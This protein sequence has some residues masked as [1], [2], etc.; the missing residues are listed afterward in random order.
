MVGEI[1]DKE[2]AEIAIHA[3]LTGHLVLST[4]HTNDAAGAVTRLVEMGVEP[5][6]VALDVIGV[7]AQRLVRML[8][9]PTQTRGFRSSGRGYG[10]R[11]PLPRNSI[12][13]GPAGGHPP[14][15]ADL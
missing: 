5:F 14:L 9:R 2:T 8:C 13:P 7:L 12:R 15:Q 6:L 11:E 10:P 4:M 3:S 1:R